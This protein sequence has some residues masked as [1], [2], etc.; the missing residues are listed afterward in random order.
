MPSNRTDRRTLDLHVEAWGRSPVIQRGERFDASVEQFVDQTPLALDTGDYCF[1]VGAGP[2]CGRSKAI[3]LAEV[4]RP[5]L[6]RLYPSGFPRTLETRTMSSNQSATQPDA[7]WP[8]WTILT[9]STPG[10][11][12][13]II[14]EGSPRHPF[15]I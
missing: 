15:T 8:G 5:I 13:R 4:V 1:G 6:R 7:S 12:V 10:W 2:S 3:E 14:P 9:R 11:A